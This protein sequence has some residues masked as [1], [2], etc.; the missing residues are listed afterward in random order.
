MKFIKFLSLITIIS[1]A[2][3][4]YSM[5]KN[6]TSQEQSRVPKLVDLCRPRAIERINACMNP[7]ALLNNQFRIATFG[8]ADELYTSNKIFQYCIDLIVNEIWD[9]CQRVTGTTLDTIIGAIKQNFLSKIPKELLS[10]IEAHFCKQKDC[11]K[12]F[13]NID[14][15]AFFPGSSLLFVRYKDNYGNYRGELIDTK[16]GKVIKEFNNVNWVYPSP[17]SSLMFIKYRDGRGELIDTKTGAVIKND[18]T[19][20]D[21]SPNSSLMI[22]LYED[23]REELIDAKSGVVLKEFDDVDSVCFPLKGSL[24]FVKY[25]DGRGELINETGAVLKE[26]NDVDWIDFSIDNSF[27]FVKHVESGRGEL[28]NIKTWEVI[29]QFDWVDSI[30]FSP[31]NSFIFVK[32]LGGSKGELINI[33]TGKVIRRSDWINRIDRIDFSPDGS[34]MFIQYVADGRR[35]LIDAKT[36]KVIKDTGAYEVYFSPDNLFIFVKYLADGK[37]ELI[38]VKTWKVMKEF[39]NVDEVD[40]SQ[41]GLL[42]FVKY[43]DGKGKLLYLSNFEQIIY[44]C[45]L[46]NTLK[47]HKEQQ[48]DEIKQGLTTLLKHRILATFPQQAQDILSKEITGV[49]QDKDSSGSAAL[50]PSKKRQKIE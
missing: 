23:G 41:D 42:M 9:Q 40:F 45:A 36:E 4:L 33:K 32:C 30:N 3:A 49:L 34:F 18:V 20:I 16:T 37:G 19:W 1:C 2:P 25:G 14:Q 5:E 31:D 6:N 47:K 22:V 50:E 17:N 28:I 44:Q 7:I 43:R 10:F 26:F 24:M 39:N 21:F 27:I 8:L 48:G 35:E 29:R 38:N 46:R 13:N 11:L 15:A 12:E